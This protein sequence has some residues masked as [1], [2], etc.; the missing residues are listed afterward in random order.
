MESRRFHRLL[1]Q[2]EITYARK[3]EARTEHSK[4]RNISIGGICI[5]T[6]GKPLKVDDIFRLEFSLPG[7]EKMITSE[8][9][10]VWNRKALD[11][12]VTFYDNGIEFM[13]LSENYR[14]MIEEYSI[15]SIETKE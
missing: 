12:G 13:G 4:T 14:A 10:V 6:L 8:G 1:L 15:G 3:S 2:V 7:Q 5:T 11:G 9:R